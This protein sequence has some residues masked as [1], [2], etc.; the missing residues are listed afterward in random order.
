MVAVQ[1]DSI[2]Q[3]QVKNGPSR[4]EEMAFAN[5]SDS[6]CSLDCVIFPESWRTYKDLFIEGNTLMISGTLDKKRDSFIAQ[7]VWQI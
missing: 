2:R 7:K 5:L 1:V 6:T 4:G 3:V